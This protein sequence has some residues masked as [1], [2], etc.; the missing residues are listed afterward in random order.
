MSLTAMVKAT[1][2][3][4]LVVYNI[5]R[6]DAGETKFAWSL[7]NFPEIYSP[8]CQSGFGNDDMVAICDPDNMLSLEEKQRITR[9]LEYSSMIDVECFDPES[10]ELK[11]M[12]TFDSENTNEAEANVSADVED[13]KKELKRNEK[14]PM[15]IAVVIV[16]EVCNTNRFFP[17]IISFSFQSNEHFCAPSIDGTIT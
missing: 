16:K 10:G 15:Q 17:L 11:Y 6:I 2:T 9:I 1:M 12:F 7:E 8:A 4:M 3:F 14:A 13:E 5:V